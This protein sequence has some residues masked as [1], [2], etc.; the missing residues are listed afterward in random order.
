MTEYI[1]K[2]LTDL[3]D[4]VSKGKKVNGIL[5]IDSREFVIVLKPEHEKYQMFVD[6]IKAIIDRGLDYHNGISLTFNSAFDKL[7]IDLIN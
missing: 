3:L 5:R 4:I 6:T 7:K 2:V 1:D